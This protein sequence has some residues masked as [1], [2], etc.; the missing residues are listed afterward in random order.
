ML[1]WSA[2]KVTGG[3]AL[4]ALPLFICKIHSLESALSLPPRFDVCAQTFVLSL[5]LAP[6]WFSIIHIL[7]ELFFSFLCP[8]DTALALPS[9]SA[10]IWRQAISHRTLIAPSNVAFIGLAGLWSCFSLLHCVCNSRLSEAGC[11][12]GAPIAMLR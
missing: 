12:L 2:K 6:A 8:I 11:W 7:L 4:L 3:R 9:T 1:A 10:V 5:S